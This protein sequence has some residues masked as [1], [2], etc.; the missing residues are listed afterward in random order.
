[1]I[2]LRYFP[3]VHFTYGIF[4]FLSLTSQF[5]VYRLYMSCLTAYNE[6]SNLL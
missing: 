6:I 3:S 5:F 4:I 2:A 1:M